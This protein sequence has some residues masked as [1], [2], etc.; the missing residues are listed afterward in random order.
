[1]NFFIG[2]VP[3]ADISASIYAIQKQFGDN[4]L[5]QHIT[6]RPPA[7]LIDKA[8]WIE[9]VE[10]ICEEIPPIIID[11]IATGNFGK[12]V[13]FIEVKSDVL[14][15][16]EKKLVNAIEPYE[17]ISTKQ[18][19]KKEY[20]PHLTLG[21]LW[22]GFTKEDFTQMKILADEYLAREQVLFSVDS[23]RI[24]YKPKGNDGYKTYKDVRLKGQ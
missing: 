24:Y 2:I 21:R 23:L 14:L 8:K 16:M 7:A 20:H 19:E 18:N 17:Q 22:C 15:K 13:L 3:P 5:E 9:V 1:M 12:R 4:R 11:L 10:S 6:L